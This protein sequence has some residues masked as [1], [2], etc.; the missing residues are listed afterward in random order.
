VEP[1]T[2]GYQSS[3]NLAKL[4]GKPCCLIFI[5]LLT[6][7]SFAVEVLLNI[8]V[9]WDDVLL[10]V[11]EVLSLYVAWKLVILSEPSYG[12]LVALKL[13]TLAQVFHGFP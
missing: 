1:V 3:L 6:A 12:S 8:A 5:A 7:S 13:G 11:R 10:H 4:S 9:Q 2:N